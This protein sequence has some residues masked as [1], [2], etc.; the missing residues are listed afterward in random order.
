MIYYICLMTIPNRLCSC[1]DAAAGS[2]KSVDEWLS[3]SFSLGK[4][5]PLKAE[6]LNN[7][8]YFVKWENSK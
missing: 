3:G 1:K 4:N 6:D 8:K 5:K 7:E 2:K